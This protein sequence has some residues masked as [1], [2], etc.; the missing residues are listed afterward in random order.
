LHIR[1]EDELTFIQK[2]LEIDN[3]NLKLVELENDIKYQSME[4]NFQ[5]VKPY[6]SPSLE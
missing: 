6:I 3:P 2:T 4:I 5:A 1:N